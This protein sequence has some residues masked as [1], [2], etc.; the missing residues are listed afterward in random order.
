MP[1]L[2]TGKNISAKKRA[3][4]VAAFGRGANVT[5]AAAHAKCSRNLARVVR[6]QHF[7]EI[8]QQKELL[9]HQCHREAS[10]ALDQI[11]SHLRKKNLSANQLVPIFGVLVDKSLALRGDQPYTPQHFEVAHHHLHEFVEKNIR[12][13]DAKVVL[14]SL[15]SGADAP[16]PQKS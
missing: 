11:S 3:Q 13:V 15:P 10:E 14:D 1:D 2:C 6:D 5:D 8:T 12:H 16:K 4:I 7:T 9:A